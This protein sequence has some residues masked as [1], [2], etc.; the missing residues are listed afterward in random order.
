MAVNI[1]DISNE[2]EWMKFR[3]TG[4][5]ASEAATLFNLNSFKSAVEYF[6]DKVGFN[7]KPF[8]NL[9]MAYGTAT[10]KLNSDLV[11]CY[12]GNDKTHA[13]NLKNGIKFREVVKLPERSFLKNDKYEHL[14]A[15]PDRYITVDGVKGF[16]EAKDTSSLYLNHFIDKVSPTHI[17][18]LR[19]QLMVGE[20]DWGLL[21]YIIDGGRSYKEHRYERD[22]I[23]F[24]DVKNGIVITEQNLAD[25]VNEFWQKVLIAREASE[26]KRKAEIHHDFKAV[27][28]WQSIIE[29][30]EPEP[31]TTLAY[32]VYMNE[33]YLTLAKPLVEIQGDES[34]EILAENF[35]Q[36]REKVKVAETDFQGVRNKIIARCKAGHRVKLS[37]KGYIQVNQGKTK[38][39]I[40]VG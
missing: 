35:K 37:G 11:A 39:N 5:G 38:S 30:C 31:D 18:Q 17:F 33:K 26:E 28:E 13:M 25:R 36:L 16:V 20:R 3:G 4:V 10:E 40:K 1:I 2:E 34:D 22:G 14:Y 7:P 15:S 19:T 24:N 6:Y 8:Y 23:I 9:R 21:S 12:D 32:E 29:R 27:R